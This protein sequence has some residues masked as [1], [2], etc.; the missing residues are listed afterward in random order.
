MSITIQQVN[1]RSLILYTI[2]VVKLSA[3]TYS[4]YGLQQE[5]AMEPTKILLDR[6]YQI[7]F[8]ISYGFYNPGIYGF[9]NIQN[10]ES[11]IWWTTIPN[12]PLT[13]YEYMYEKTISANADTNK[14]HEQAAPTQKEAFKIKQQRKENLEQGDLQR[15]T[16]VS[17]HYFLNPV[18]QNSRENNQTL[19]ETTT[20]NS[21][22]GEV[23]ESIYIPHKPR[24]IDEEKDQQQTAYLASSDL[25]PSEI[26]GIVV[27]S[28][29][30]IGLILSV[31]S[32]VYIYFQRPDNLI[33]SNQLIL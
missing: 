15:N 7:E 28:V 21:V 32:V 2:L 9:P 16:L 27:G 4:N 13:S 17:V 19:Q 26:T 11:K 18:Q 22:V 29:L 31:V 30:F 24:Y 20:A 3:Q 5:V 23:E 33:Q 14:P 12:P 25:T 1:F 6:K 8:P 10:V